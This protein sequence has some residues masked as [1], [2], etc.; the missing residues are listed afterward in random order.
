MDYMYGH[1]EATDIIRDEVFRLGSDGASGW[2][3]YS[4]E[5]GYAP[6]AAY[7][8]QVVTHKYSLVG[9]YSED[10][11]QLLLVQDTIFFRVGG[12]GCT[13]FPGKSFCVSN[14]CCTGAC[15]RCT[16]NDTC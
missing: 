2:I 14:G 13:S 7:L 5:T 11:Q 15:C 9:Y 16:R 8:Y 1:R 3:A 4:N 12:V 10:T 6:A